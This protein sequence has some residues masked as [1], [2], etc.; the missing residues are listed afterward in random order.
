[1]LR[2]RW[3]RPFPAAL[4]YPL[5][6]QLWLPIAS[7][8]AWA[9]ISALLACTQAAYASSPAHGQAADATPVRIGVLAFLGEDAARHEWGPLA[10]YLNQALPQARFAMQYLGLGALRQAVEQGQVDFVLT[11][12]G[13]YVEL[14][15]AFGV[16]RIV[17]LAHG[18][19]PTSHQGVAAT[20]V[21]A[22]ERTDLERLEDLRGQT[23]A[24]ISSEGFG[25]YQIIWR[26]LDALGIDPQRD[27]RMQFVGYPMQQVLRAID[28]RQADA[29]IVR[30]CLL[31]TVPNWR[32]HYKVVAG[33]FEPALGCAVSSPLYPN[34]PLASLRHTSSE[35][36]RAVAI[37]LL[38]MDPQ[39]HGLGWTVP[40]DYQSIHDVFRQLR[41]GSYDYLRATSLQHT[42]QAYWP[43][44]LFCL[45]AL[46]CW[47]AYTL[48]VEYLVRKRTAALEQALFE[49]EALQQRMRAHQEQVDHLSRLSVLG[50]LSSTLAHELNQPLAGVSN[51]AQSLLR[52]LDNGRLN[53]EAVREASTQIVTLSHTAAGI[54]KRIKGFVRK[55]PSTREDCDPAALVRDAIALFKGMQ[56]HPPQMEVGGA[57]A[58]HTRVK[59]DPLQIQ[60]ILLN[61]FK[62]AQDAM[63]AQSPDTAR[64]HIQLDEQDG[65]LWIHVRDW[66]AGMSDA[67]MQRLFESF[68][69]TK[70]DGLGLG[71][72]ICKSI[73]EAHGGQL[74]ATRPSSGPGMVFSLSLPTV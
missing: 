56:L 4:F 66:G 62:N 33:Q 44:V 24:A 41:I 32:Q 16:S 61:F 1:M 20:V 42:I 60:Q 57:L 72:S 47:A 50:E 27:L 30:A 68:Y 15:V 21:A 29:G 19:T 8:L 39:R 26:E 2:F 5:A 58:P 9:W 53:D 67:Q 63:Q 65:W 7:R 64:I 70:A 48:R 10:D 14:E 17:T 13:Q 23:L 55:R 73:A 22:R 52:R 71:L 6:R 36:A 45:L 3:R 11:N 74:Q 34:W 59:V 51:Y 69:T 49:R 28:L 18:R 12:P 35:L 43:Y 46:L 37:A 38:K 31:E 54:L 40:A 25:G